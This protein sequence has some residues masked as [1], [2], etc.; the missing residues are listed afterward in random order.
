MDVPSAQLRDGT[1]IFDGRTSG[2][3]QFGDVRWVA[4]S[5]WW[6]YTPGAATVSDS[7][8]AGAYRT[9]VARWTGGG[10]TSLDLSVNGAGFTA[11][12]G[13]LSTPPSVFTI[14]NYWTGGVN[15]ALDGDVLW[16][17]CGSGTLT[18]TDAATINSFGNTDPKVSSFP[19]SAQ[20][21]LVWDGISPAGSLK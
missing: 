1:R 15:A 21:T 20:A 17:A 9:F 11:G 6:R 19:S 4:A 18:N 12:S 7:W 8:S 2:N 13:V 14:G 3:A 5:G 16:F 10:S